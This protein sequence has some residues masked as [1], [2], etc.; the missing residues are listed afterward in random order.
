MYGVV[1]T[2]WEIAVV[3]GLLAFVALWVWAAKWAAKQVALAIKSKKVSVKLVVAIP[4]LAI[5][6]L[7]GSSF[8]SGFFG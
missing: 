4:L 8:F 5:L 1:M 7:T 3:V 6:A 2:V